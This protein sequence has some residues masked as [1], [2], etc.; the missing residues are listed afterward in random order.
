MLTHPFPL[1]LVVVE[2]S[3]HNEQE[4]F[5]KVVVGG[6]H[7]RPKVEGCEKFEFFVSFQL[8]LLLRGHHFSQ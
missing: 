7:N 3:I 6:C 1:R 4:N 8:I 2:L 5:R